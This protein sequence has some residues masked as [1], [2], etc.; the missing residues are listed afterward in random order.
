MSGDRALAADFAGDV[1][2]KRDSERN[3]R[4]GQ[5]GT[6]DISIR[7]P[8]QLATIVVESPE[9]VRYVDDLAALIDQFPS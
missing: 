3:R 1:W 9:D 5:Q 8:N 2:R 7:D 4:L 6:V